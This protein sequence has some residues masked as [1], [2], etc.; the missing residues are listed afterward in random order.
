MS[1]KEIREATT[2]TLIMK[3][4]GMM[5]ESRVYKSSLSLAKNISD[6]LEH[7]GVIKDSETFYKEWERKYTI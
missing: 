1:K 2:D 5:M 3:L 4:C 6:E 7:R